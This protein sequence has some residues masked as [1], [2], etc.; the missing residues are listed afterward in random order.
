MIDNGSAAIHHRPS[1]A[2][3]IATPPQIS[4]TIVDVTMSEV[5]HG[6]AYFFTATSLARCNCCY[7]ADRSA[8][9]FLAA[10]TCG[11]SSASAFFQR[12]ANAV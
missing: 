11:W 10:A 9:F 5:L 12:S 2:T 6:A 1:P 4:V 8:I 7:F 3:R